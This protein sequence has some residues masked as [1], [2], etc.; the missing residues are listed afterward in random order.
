MVPYV[1]AQQHQHPQPALIEGKYTVDTIVRAARK[2]EDRRTA[3]TQILDAR[4]EAAY[5]SFT[6]SGA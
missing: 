5:P 1:V 2:L 3:S 6:S 4:K